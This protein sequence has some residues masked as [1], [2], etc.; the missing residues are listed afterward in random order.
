M[1]LDDGGFDL[2][3]EDGGIRLPAGLP[4]RLLEA[5]GERTAGRPKR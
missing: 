2:M 1:L 4:D 3:D 5:R